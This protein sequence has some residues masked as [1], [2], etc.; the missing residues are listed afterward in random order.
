MG[1][2]DDWEQ[3][4]DL[5]DE[6]RQRGIAPNVI[7]Y[8]SAITAA[9]KGKQSATAVALIRRMREEGI[10]PDSITCVTA[11]PATAT[12]TATTTPGCCCR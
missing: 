4:L 2:T 10:E 7:T 5:L 3:A 11:L 9:G 1:K 8:N 12:A 6:M